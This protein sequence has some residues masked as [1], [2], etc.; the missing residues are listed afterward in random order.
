VAGNTMSKE[1]ALKC[2]EDFIK[3]FDGLGFHNC[4]K[5]ALEMAYENMGKPRKPHII[6]AKIDEATYEA[7]NRMCYETDRTASEIVRMALIECL[8]NHTDQGGRTP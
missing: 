2:L 6:S 3:R 8:K 5:T 1:T 7:L 4:Y